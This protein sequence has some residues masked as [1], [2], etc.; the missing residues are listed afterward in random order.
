MNLNEFYHCTALVHS[1]IYVDNIVHRFTLQIFRLFNYVGAMGIVVL[2]FEVFF[3]CF[4]FYFL[5]RFINKV[6]KEKMKYFKNF[7]QLME[8]LLLVLSISVMAMYIFKHI[9]TE[10]A[11]TSLS[12]RKSCKYIVIHYAQ[13]G[14]FNQ[15][16]YRTYKGPI[17]SGIKASGPHST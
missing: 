7:W 15:F 5:V 17:P 12:K 14:M 9:L 10:A 16:T 6:K 4:T 3:G 2:C 1:S 11:M 8:L 13:G